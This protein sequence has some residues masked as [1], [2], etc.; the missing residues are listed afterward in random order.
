LKGVVIVT[1]IDTSDMR[2]AARVASEAAQAE[3]DNATDA[4]LAA[5]L[6]DREAKAKAS[7]LE[8]RKTKAA[9]AAT[10]LFAVPAPVPVPPVVDT[11][12]VPPT[13]VPAP[14]PAPP[15]ESPEEMEAR[16]RREVDADLRARHLAPV[17]TPPADDPAPMQDTPP[18][19]GLDAIL[20]NS[21]S[22]DKPKKKT[23]DEHL[24]RFSPAQYIGAFIGLIFAIFVWQGTDEVIFDLTNEQPSDFL[25]SAGWFAFVFGG[26]IF[27][28]GL[29]G[30]WIDRRSN[31]SSNDS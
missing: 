14:L 21:T 22:V 7:A 16:I 9:A 6:A 29:I 2:E 26:L 27:T 25:L 1:T 17:P 8:A 13:P 15:V 31:S 10:T 19:D 28:G 23:L 24:S 11:P 5:E 3:H 12:V 4:L 20:D 30:A 18:D